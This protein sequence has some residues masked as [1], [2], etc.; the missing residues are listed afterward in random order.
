MDEQ[1]RD[2]LTEQIRQLERSKRRWKLG[3]LTSAAAL[4]MV[5]ILGGVL[6][7][8]GITFLTLRLQRQQITLQQ[9][10]ARA[11][12]EAVRLQAEQAAQQP[13]QKEGEAKEAEKKTPNPARAPLP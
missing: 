7:L 3:T 11:A 13:R 8:S 4:A 5:L 9:E 1:E 12:E 10:A 2:Y 6:M